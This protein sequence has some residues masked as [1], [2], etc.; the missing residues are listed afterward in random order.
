MHKNKIIIC[1]LIL[2]ITIS[3]FSTN[4]ASNKYE[5][6]IVE[7]DK[8]NIIEN[9]NI[10]TSFQKQ[11]P[12]NS[13]Y[14]VSN[15]FLFNNLKGINLPEKYCLQDY[16]NINVYKQTG[17][18]CWIY[19]TNSIIETTLAKENKR[20]IEYNKYN[21]T[22][23]E[24]DSTK[25][26]NRKIDGGGN[27][28]LALA[29]YTSGYGPK[30]NASGEVDTQIGDYIFLASI[31]KSKTNGGILYNDGNYT[32]Q[33]VEIIRNNIKK[34]IMEHGAVTA[35]MYSKGKEYFNEPDDYLNSEAY[36]C[37]YNYKLNG[38]NNINPDHQVTIIGWDDGYSK[39]N[40]NSQHKPENDGAYIVLNSWGKEFSEDGIFYVSYEDVFIESSVYGVRN[41]DDKDYDNLYQHDELGLRNVMI[42]KNQINYGANV[43]TR[44]KTEK[45]VLTEV[46]IANL[47][48][49][50][51][52]IYVNK[53][54]GDLNF[55]K[56][57]K[58]AETEVLESGYH[59]IELKNEIVLTGKQ[60]VVAVKY[61]NETNGLTYFGVEYTD[62]EESKKIG[63]ESYWKNAKINEGESFVCGENKGEWGDI[64]EIFA[65]EGISTEQKQIKNLCIKAFT[66]DYESKDVMGELEITSKKYE[67]KDKYILGIQVNTKIN[68][69]K[70]NILTNA[71][72]V[73]FYEGSVKVNNNDNMKTGMSLIL[74]KG[75]E[76]VGYKVVV[77]GDSNGDGKVNSQDL[78]NAVKQYK[79]SKTKGKK[80]TSL[81]DE[82]LLAIKYSTS[83]TYTPY[84]L[85]R[86]VREYKKYK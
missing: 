62:E 55:N 29:L 60:F 64:S 8:I 78:I 83:D 65:S 69:F 63:Q 23:A 25:I 79:Y 66:K 67:L 1:F 14:G 44:N 20:T 3:I 52:E 73:E 59:T 68:E 11:L 40:F 15:I 54:D 2:F 9:G 13:T 6:F 37:D 43:F 24:Q 71:E 81:K 30:T 34:H 86:Q 49:S 32:K 72:N 17:N 16:I 53:N 76:K 10:I 80:G 41:V 58:V 57:E 70:N 27:P 4:Y 50:A 35:S 46:S 48:E 61:K 75:K 5:D 31:I 12:Q 21:V 84:D 39:N 19:S 26:Y 22:A 82:Y 56:F 18:T 38:S 77:I 7:T 51:Y 42:F 36:Y 85:I 74:K 47:V 28:G 33:Q 45:E